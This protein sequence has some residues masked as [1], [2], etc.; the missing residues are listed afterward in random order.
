M[1]APAVPVA[2]LG[3][4]ATQWYADAEV[5]IAVAI[6]IPINVAAKKRLTIASLMFMLQHKN[7]KLL[8]IGVKVFEADFP[9][10]EI[11]FVDRRL[12]R[13]PI[14]KDSGLPQGRCRCFRG[15]LRVR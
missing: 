6:A 1:R 13:R 10:E 14:Q 9:L 4:R 15:N 8:L 5:E 12:S 2:P 3:A 11:G 7:S